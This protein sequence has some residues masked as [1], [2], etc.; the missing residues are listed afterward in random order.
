MIVLSPAELADVPLAWPVTGTTVLGHGHIADF[1]QDEVSTPDGQTIS[2]EY[3][4][5]PGAVGVVAL[6]AE[7]RVALVRQYRHPVRHRLVEPPA[8]LLDVEGEEPLAAVQRELAEEADL[9]AA[10]WHVLVDLFSTPGMV[11]EGIRVY[12]ARELSASSAPEGFVREGE[13]ADMDVVWAPL[14]DLVDAVLA[15]R[16]HSPTL[17]SGVL[18]AEAARVRGWSTLRPAGAPWP[19][20]EHLLRATGQLSA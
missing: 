18:A 4:Q 3:L 9:A 17:V 15:G 6:D 16:L 11:G 7:E 20:R 2:R 13:E 1:R 14:A 10:R 8:G 19:S 5:H 12:L